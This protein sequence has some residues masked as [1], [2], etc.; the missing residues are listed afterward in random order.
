MAAS[1][2]KSRVGVA[3]L[4][5]LAEHAMRTGLDQGVA[6][7]APFAPAPALFALFFVGPVAKVV[8]LELAARRRPADG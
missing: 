1:R 2:R 8:S 6:W 5:A 4:I 7:L 3:V